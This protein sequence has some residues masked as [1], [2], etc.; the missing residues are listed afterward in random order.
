MTKYERYW[1]FMRD[2]VFKD[3]KRGDMPGILYDYFSDIDVDIKYPTGEE[4]EQAI[5]HLMEEE[6]G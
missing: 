4:L 3:M 1:L 2:H 5:E 6:N